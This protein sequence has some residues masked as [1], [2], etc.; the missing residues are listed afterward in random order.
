MV[1]IDKTLATKSIPAKLDH[2]YKVVMDAIMLEASFPFKS[3]KLMSEIGGY[4]IYEIYL[5][6]V[7]ANKKGDARQLRKFEELIAGI[8]KTLKDKHLIDPNS[9]LG[10][11]GRAI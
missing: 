9:R 1:E 3:I 5:R 2:N 4:H 6:A 10:K 11:G 7:S 8:F